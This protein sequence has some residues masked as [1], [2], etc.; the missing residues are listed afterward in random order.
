MTRE[1]KLTKEAKYDEEISGC[2]TKCE[3]GHVVAM[4][5]TQSKTI[6]YWCGR[7]IRNNSKQY[8][9]YNLKKAMEK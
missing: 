8:F 3:C 6:C 9:I 5:V 1:K 4:P 7:I 2:K